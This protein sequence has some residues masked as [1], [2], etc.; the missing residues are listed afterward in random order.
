MDKVDINVRTIGS[1]VV[2]DVSG[3]AD[4][5]TDFQFKLREVGA[6]RAKNILL[7]LEKVTYIDSSG[8]AAVIELF[9]E[10]RARHGQLFLCNLSPRLKNVFEILRLENVMQI[11]SSEAQALQAF[12]A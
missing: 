11:H 9:Q 6:T 8:L 1:V 12:E 4:L 3:S 7:N 5:E 10:V 2:I